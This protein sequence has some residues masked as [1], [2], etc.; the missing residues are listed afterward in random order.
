M[1]V[2]DFDSKAMKWWHP[3]GKRPGSVV[4]VG[5]G[6]TKA[7]LLDTTSALNP[8]KTLMDADEW[9]GVNAAVNHLGGRVAYDLVFIMDYLDGEAHR[10]PEYADRIG[11]HIRR[12]GTRIITSQAGQFADNPNVYE[13]PF[14]WLYKRLG[15][16]EPYFRNSLPYMIA[17][18]VAIGVQEISLWG[19]DYSWNGGTV[20]EDDKA[21]CEY[22]VGF[23]R[24][25]GV[26]VNIPRTSTLC[27]ANEGFH[28]YGY[29]E[30]PRMTVLKALKDSTVNAVL[31]SETADAT[32][33]TPN[34]RKK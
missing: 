27:K 3:T 10:C 28:F 34:G 22:W 31:I 12:W 8:D 1:T 16:T 21:N 7:D 25:R 17:Y 29:R 30:Q 15:C 18:A 26:T 2:L 11:E 20:R 13:F 5:L 6:P 32:Q 19:V 4:V 9:W 23:A 14:H 24:A 33:E